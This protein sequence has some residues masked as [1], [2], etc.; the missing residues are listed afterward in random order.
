MR[1]RATEAQRPGIRKTTNTAAPRLASLR[2]FLSRRSGAGRSVALFV[3][4]LLSPMNTQAQSTACASGRSP[5]RALAVPTGIAVAAA[6][7]QRMA[8][9][10]SGAASATQLGAGGWHVASVPTTSAVA[11]DPASATHALGSY[12]LA[13]LGGRA[14]ANRCASLAQ[15]TLGGA[16]Y[17]GGVGVL[18]ELADGWS[19]GFS[20]ADLAVNAAGIGLALG[21][22][23]VPALRSVTPTVSVQPVTLREGAAAVTAWNAQ[24]YWLSADVHALLPEEVATRWPQ[25]LRVSAGTSVG[26]S[27]RQFVLGLDL[28]AAQLPGTHPA[29]VAVKEALHF[30]RLPGPALVFGANGQRAVT[31]YW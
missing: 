22:M 15:Q 8:G 12:H 18:K 21:Q 25:A 13:R 14:F 19:T 5:A 27:G 20:V 2:S 29:W 7:A 17:S 4:G 10:R 3:I 16:L 30:V 28:D 1:E 23:H 26:S 6:S 31:L 11:Q 24:T 9:S